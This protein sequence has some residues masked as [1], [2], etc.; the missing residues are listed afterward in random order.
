[1][2]VSGSSSGEAGRRSAKADGRAE[3]HGS[4]PRAE[5]GATIGTRAPTQSTHIKLWDGIGAAKSRRPAS[6]ISTSRAGTCQIYFVLGSQRLC[7]TGFGC[8][9]DRARGADL[10]TGLAANIRSTYLKDPGPMV[11]KLRTRGALGRSRCPRA[12]CQSRPPPS[13]SW[14]LWC[15]QP[16]LGKRPVLYC[17]DFKLGARHSTLQAQVGLGH[18]RRPIVRIVPCGCDASIRCRRSYRCGRE[19]LEAQHRGDSL[20]SRPDGPARSDCSST[21]TTA[22]SSRRVASHRLSAHA[23]HGETRHSHPE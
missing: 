12:C 7:R 17:R 9:P 1:M 3:I 6:S 21:S 10:P 22:A 20:F 13:L 2:R 19:A 23:P 8:N 5:S 11:R 15:K 14:W 4:G 18:S 16:A